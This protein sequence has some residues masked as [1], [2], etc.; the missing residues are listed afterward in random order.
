MTATAAKI[1]AQVRQLDRFE[2]EPRLRE[3]IYDKLTRA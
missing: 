3:A 1:V 2:T